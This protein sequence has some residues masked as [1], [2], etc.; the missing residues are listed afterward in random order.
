MKVKLFILTITLS[1]MCPFV[2]ANVYANENGA[3]TFE[4]ESASCVISLLDES[5]YN[6]MTTNKET[7]EIV[8]LTGNYTKEDKILTLYFNG[9]VFYVFEIG[10]NNQLTIYEKSSEIEN[11][12]TNLEELKEV[13][14]VIKNVVDY[15][16]AGVL[17]LLGTTGVA[18]IFKGILKALIDKITQSINDLKAEKDNLEEDLTNTKNQ[19]EK[20]LASLEKTSEQLGL[21]MQ[22]TMAQMKEENKEE[23]EKLKSDLALIK[24]VLPYI[25]GGMSELVK[26]G[27]AENV[28]NLL[29]EG[30][31][32]ENES[33]EI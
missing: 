9:E 2:V 17:G 18:L 8:E 14:D 31:I 33:E 26:K 29:D 4:D 22:K 3:Y 12:T 28:C 25:A 24:K 15:I 5:T 11:T 32:E 16:I 20:V 6:C 21:D 30:E 10:E 1:L 7:Y 23:F 13:E 19:A 27:I